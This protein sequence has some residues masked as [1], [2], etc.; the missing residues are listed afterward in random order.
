MAAGCLGFVGAGGMMRRGNAMRRPD[1]ALDGKQARAQLAM[2]LAN[3]TDPL[4]ASHDEYSL[5]RMFRVPL[6][7]IAADLAAER[8]RRAA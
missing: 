3:I 2:L 4:L 1:A 7:T 5:G 6:K 8:A